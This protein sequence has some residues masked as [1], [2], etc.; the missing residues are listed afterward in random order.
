MVPITFLWVVSFSDDQFLLM[1]LLALLAVL[2]VYSLRLAFY[3]L[4]HLWGSKKFCKAAV[5]VA[6]IPRICFFLLGPLVLQS[7][8]LR[9]RRF[10]R[11]RQPYSVTQWWTFKSP[12][13][14]VIVVAFQPYLCLRL[15]LLFL[16]DRR[17]LSLVPVAVLV[18]LSLL[19]GHQH[20]SFAQLNL[21]ILLLS[22]G[23][24]A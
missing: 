10:F 15:N 13:P 4:A 6:K 2:H 7:Q 24:S 5:V 18:I 9:A 21:S 12:S 22:W 11:D 19:L 23:P 3:S 8:T 1:E 16:Q 17:L 14:F 20:Y